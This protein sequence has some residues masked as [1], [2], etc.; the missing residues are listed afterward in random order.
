MPFNAVLS[1][2]THFRARLLAPPQRGARNKKRTA[3]VPNMDAT[4]G[5]GI[6]SLHNEKD[7]TVT[8]KSSIKGDA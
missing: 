1:D 3:F 6:K 4:I 7:C 8:A 5:Q 2:K